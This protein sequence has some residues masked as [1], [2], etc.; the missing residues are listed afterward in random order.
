MDEG[1]RMA[2]SRQDRDG[3]RR[4]SLDRDRILAA[5]IEL[6]DTHGIE[7]LTMR[8][9]GQELGVEAMSLYNHVANKDALLAGMINAVFAEVTL[10]SEADDWKHALR[11]RAL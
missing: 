8:R 6:A 3:G 4:R 9:L 5:A 7:S 2:Q 10:P 11:T 1:E